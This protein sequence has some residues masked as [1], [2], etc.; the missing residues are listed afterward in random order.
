MLGL[1][2]EILSTT[3]FG[4][5]AHLEGVNIPPGLKLPPLDLVRLEAEQLPECQRDGIGSIRAVFYSQKR[6]IVT[7]DNDDRPLPEPLAWNTSFPNLFKFSYFAHTQDVPVELLEP[8]IFTLKM[9][10]RVLEESTED[11]LRAIGHYLPNQDAKKANYVM[12]AN[13]RFK[14]C[15][16]LMKSV[17]DRPAEAMPY[18]EAAVQADQLNMG[19]ATK[20]P[21]LANPLLWTQ[22]CE[23]RTLAGVFT[24]ETKVALEHA[25]MAMDSPKV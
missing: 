8:V 21:W 20:A 12:L 9:F 16:H 19:K 10:I 25:L 24:D 23:A 3:S 1:R 7:G 11:Q 22:Y 14:L 4:P 6:G 15:Q 13:S 2:N 18:F 17:I 5:R